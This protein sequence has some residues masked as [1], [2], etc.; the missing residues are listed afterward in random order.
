[1][2]N[3][4]DAC[5][6]GVRFLVPQVPPIA[7]FL[8][9]REQFGPSTSLPRGRAAAGSRQRG[10]IGLAVH[11]QHHPQRCARWGL[12]VR[13]LPHGE[14]KEGGRATPPLRCFYYHQQKGG[15][16]VVALFFFGDFIRMLGDC[17]FPFFRGILAP[18]KK[19]PEVVFECVTYICCKAGTLI[20]NF[21]V[22]RT[23]ANVNP[24][25]HL[26]T[27]P[28]FPSINSPASGVLAQIL[29][30]NVHQAKPSNNIR[31][32]DGGKI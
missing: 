12:S 26:K 6:M 1:M 10:P 19:Y 23:E 32:V 8:W 28:H 29:I 24:H 17:C 2:L 15:G 5:L 3:V 27:K 4:A 16:N 14:P 11:P 13:T 7:S 9:T 18:Q 22:Q 30:L 21:F 31:P 25:R 20:G